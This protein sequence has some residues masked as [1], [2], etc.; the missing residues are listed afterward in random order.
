MDPNIVT[1]LH[2]QLHPNKKAEIDYNNIYLKIGLQRDISICCWLTEWK[3]VD[4]SW[5]RT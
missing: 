5:V 3:L 1:V 4:Y 2:L